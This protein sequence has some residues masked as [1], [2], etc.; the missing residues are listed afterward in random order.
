MRT[1][2]AER[3][4]ATAPYE[5]FL[6]IKLTE[7]CPLGSCDQDSPRCEYHRL[8][9]R[10]QLLPLLLFELNQTG[11]ILKLKAWQQSKSRTTFKK[12]WGINT[13]ASA[14]YV[15]T[16]VL[17]QSLSIIKNPG[18]PIQPGLLISA[19]RQLSTA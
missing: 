17:L 4:S 10:E 13:L 3:S 14:S 12:K 1:R 7:N 5:I 16:A 11:Q 15:H 2:L 18:Q 19:W 8:H 6:L 9:N